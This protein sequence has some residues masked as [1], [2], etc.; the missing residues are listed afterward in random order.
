MASTNYSAAEDFYEE[1]GDPNLLR[2][3]YMRHKNAYR[4]Y[5]SNIYSKSSWSS[6]GST[7]SDLELI[8]GS[9][10]KITVRE[11]E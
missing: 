4:D 1:H 10:V 5:L 3:I 8:K 7:A 9:N 6:R 2:Y 11:M